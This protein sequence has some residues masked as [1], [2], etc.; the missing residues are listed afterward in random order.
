MSYLAPRPS[1]VLRRLSSCCVE[2]LNNPTS[3]RQAIISSLTPAKDQ[4]REKTSY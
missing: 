2:L 4:R 3:F 1:Q